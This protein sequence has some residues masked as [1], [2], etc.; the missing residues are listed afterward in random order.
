MA[1]AWGVHR[2]VDALEEDP[3]IDSK[4]IVVT[5]H[6]RY[7]KMALIA[8]AFDERIA[9][10]VPSHSGAGGRRPRLSASSSGRAGNCTTSPARSRTGS[11][12][13]SAG[14]SGRSSPPVSQQHELRA[15]VAPRALLDT[16]GTQDAWTNPEGSQMTYRAARRVYEF[17][18]AGDR[19][20]IRY[21]PVGHIPS[22]EDLLEFADHVFFGK[23]L[24]GEF[25]KL[26]YPEEKDGLDWDARRVERSKKGPSR[27]LILPSKP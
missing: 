18:G 2:V 26:A 16:E 11:G 21:R 1:W 9:L 20:S 10:T 24:S 13:G 17:L 14:S 27:P 23:P 15:L 4:K 7:G 25:G 12:R 3:R 19:I 22:N 8:G 5:G 6:S